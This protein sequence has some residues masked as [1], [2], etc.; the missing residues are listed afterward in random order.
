MMW[1]EFHFKLLPDRNVKENALKAAKRHLWY[2]LETNIRLALLN[3]LITHGEKEMML[4]N[5]E[6]RRGRKN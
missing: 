6:S 4:Q 1:K 2:L 3:K 5:L